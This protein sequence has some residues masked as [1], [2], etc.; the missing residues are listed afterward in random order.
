MTTAPKSGDIRVNEFDY[1]G[2]IVVEQLSH[3]NGQE[4]HWAVPAWEERGHPDL[5]GPFEDV[6]SA[7]RAV[8]LAWGAG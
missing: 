2:D 5:A 8:R 1:D 3:W 7:R 4:M 6:A